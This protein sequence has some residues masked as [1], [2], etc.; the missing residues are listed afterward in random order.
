M[1]K[2]IVCGIVAVVGMGLWIRP[3]AA[4]KNFVPDWTF[5]GSSLTGFRTVG[6]ADWHAEN[7]EIVGVPRSAAG[8]WLILDRPLQDVEFATTFAARAGAGPG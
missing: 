4:N 3:A 5:K 1:R 6:E 8:G 2:Q 7:G